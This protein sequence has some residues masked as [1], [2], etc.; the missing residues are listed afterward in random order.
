VT[1]VF[2]TLISDSAFKSLDLDQM[3]DLVSKCGTNAYH[4]VLPDAGRKAF[5]LDELKVKFRL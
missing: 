5:M 1:V 4:T 2:N 3:H